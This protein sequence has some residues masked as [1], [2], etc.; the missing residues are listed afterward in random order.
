[1]VPLL[2]TP[3]LLI[4]APCVSPS[5]VTNYVDILPATLTLNFDPPP[6]HESAKTVSPEGLFEQ[7]QYAEQNT[8][9]NCVRRF[10]QGYSSV[11]G[12]LKSVTFYKK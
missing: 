12:A 8:G 6:L 10:K 2:C 11:T 1:M 5:K 9:H 3:A 7:S 4:P